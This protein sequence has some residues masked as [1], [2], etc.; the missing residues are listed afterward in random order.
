MKHP[1]EYWLKYMIVFSGLSLEQIAQTAVMYEIMEPN[2]GYL[3]DL[4]SKLEETKPSPF[5]LDFGRT[6]A[7]VRRQ[8]LMSLAREDKSAI[9]ARGILGNTKCRPVVEYL[10]LA[11]TPIEEVSSYTEELTGTKFSKRVIKMYS[12]YFW[13]RDLLSIDQWLAVFKAHP[14]G[15]VLQSCYSQGKEYALWKLGYRVDVPADE[16]F[17]SVFHEST[18]RFL[19][20][21]NAPNNKD[22]A[23]CAKMWAESLF[24]ASEAL[25][26]VGDPMKEVMKEIRDIAINLGRRDISS[27]EDLKKDGGE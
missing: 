11:G 8:R 17:R 14:R 1:S 22:T 24:K 21:S 10:L 7:W 6:K 16:V 23:M 5:R 27:L 19:E 18:M 4:R 3:R 26:R 9:K 2:I 15:D 12:H 20:T 13:N 25:N